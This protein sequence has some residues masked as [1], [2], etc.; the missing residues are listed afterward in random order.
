[1][2]RR[3]SEPGLREDL[4]LAAANRRLFAIAR[5]RHGGDRRVLRPVPAGRISGKRHGGTMK[6][7]LSIDGGGMRGV[8]PALILARLEQTSGIRSAAMFDLIAGTS[9]GGIIACGL[10]SGIEAW[11]LWEMY[12]S[13]GAEIFSR[14]WYRPSAVVSKY[15]ASGIE[16]VLDDVFGTM[17]FAF[18]KTKL[19]VPT[20]DT[21]A[22]AP[23]H[24]KSWEKPCVWLMKEAARATSA[25]PT[26]FPAAQKRYVDGG[27]FANDPAMNA[28]AEAR[29]L[30]PGEDL[31]L[32]SVGTGF[33]GGHTG[34]PA[35]GGLLRWAKPILGTLFNAPAADVDYMAATCLGPGYVRL[36][37]ELPDDVNPEMDDASAKNIAA[38]EAFAE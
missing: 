28:Y 24:L 30:W 5:R 20:F 23:Y 18:A 2:A 3:E 6:R 16:K 26:Y 1:M 13:R 22:D 10:G 7:I 38:L 34:Y 29:R 11:R 15:S 37:G 8:I 12:K 32:L 9:T 19:L 14:P 35:N 25:A 33:K 31:F 17:P 21:Q 27:L 4:G 36:N